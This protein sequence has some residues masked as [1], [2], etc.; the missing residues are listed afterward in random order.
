MTMEDII[1]WI[2]RLILALLSAP[3]SRVTGRLDD[4]FTRMRVEVL[5]TKVSV[6]LV[7]PVGLIGLFRY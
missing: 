3:V 7:N 5:I 4:D 6:S 1:Q 2:P